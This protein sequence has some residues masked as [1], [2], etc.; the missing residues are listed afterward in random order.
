MKEMHGLLAL[1]RD[2]VRG[3]WEPDV[4]D[5]GAG[6]VAHLVLE[7]VVPTTLLLPRVPV[8]TLHKNVT[9]TY[10]VVRELY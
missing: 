9:D 4:R 3:R 1:R 2:G 8:K 6:D 7:H 5:A 10:S